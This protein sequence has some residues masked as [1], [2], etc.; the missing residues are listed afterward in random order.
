MISL[1]VSHRG[2]TSHDSGSVRFSRFGSTSRGSCLARFARFSRKS[3]I[4]FK[5]TSDTHVRYCDPQ[6]PATAPYDPRRP[7]TTGDGSYVVLTVRF[8]ESRF[9]WFSRFGFTRVTVR[10]VLTVRF[11]EPRFAWLS[12]FGFTSHGS[13]GSHGSVSRATVRF[14]EQNL[15]HYTSMFKQKLSPPL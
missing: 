7:V 15:N 9:A 3:S 4:D 1:R 10:M 12:R 11:H 5:F 6:R 14:H 13:H 8:H 2:I